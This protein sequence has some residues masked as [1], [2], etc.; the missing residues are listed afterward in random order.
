MTPTNDVLPRTQQL[1]Q[2]D[3]EG[4]ELSPLAPARWNSTAQAAGFDNQS[5]MRSTR[6]GSLFDMWDDGDDGP[7]VAM[8]DN[9][10][11]SD[12]RRDVRVLAWERR[13]GETSITHGVRLYLSNL[14]PDASHEENC[15]LLLRPASLRVMMRVVVLGVETK[16]GQNE[17]KK[18]L[19]GRKLVLGIIQRYA[20]SINVISYSEVLCWVRSICQRRGGV[21]T[22]VC[23][24]TPAARML[25]QVK[26]TDRA[27]FPH[28]PAN[29]VTSYVTY[30]K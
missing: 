7:A 29:P 13:P 15:N 21:P 2:L 10:I 11:D 6:T 3:P 18:Q 28:I 8:S 23:D 4:Q 19:S 30:S 1:G 17:K 9:Y 20:R 12:L 14:Y 16:R 27:R 22:H 5:A 24:K 25:S 26:D